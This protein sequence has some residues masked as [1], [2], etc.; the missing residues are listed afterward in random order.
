MSTHSPDLMRA[1]S[2]PLLIG[3]E[4]DKHWSELEC[5]VIVLFDEYR[6]RLLSFVTAFSL[7]GHDAEEVVQEVFLS[8]FRHLI[9]GKSRANLRGWIF[10]VA[11]NLALKQRYANQQRQK[12]IE[13]EEFVE[14][15]LY[16]PSP[17]PEEHAVSAQQRQRM[18]SVVNALPEQDRL[19]FM[20]R[21]EGLRYR[22]IAHVLGISLG[23]VALS[24]TRSMGRLMRA[25]E[26]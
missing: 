24:L 25:A 16:D 4:R 19:C 17:T 12:R 18:L 7:T 8:L 14:K 15:P 20:L 21:A 6:D 11:H 22:E 3:Q 2:L 1:R 9:A 5:E 26:M 23:S 10:R 13:S